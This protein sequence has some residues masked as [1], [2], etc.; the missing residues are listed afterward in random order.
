MWHYIGLIFSLLESLKHGKMCPWKA[1]KS[2][3]IFGWK[4]C[5]NPALCISQIRDSPPP[6]SGRTPDSWWE[7]SSVWCGEFVWNAARENVARGKKLKDYMEEAKGTQLR[8]RQQQNN[9]TW[10]LSTGLCCLNA[11]CIEYY[12]WLLKIGRARKYVF[13]L[14][15]Q[16]DF[17]SA[18]SSFCCRSSFTFEF[19][20]RTSCN[21]L[22]LVYL[23]CA[24]W[25]KVCI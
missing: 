19:S 9:V 12:H 2:P 1:L 11:L 25:R 15:G 21:W 24:Y 7:V 18:F 22:F 3:W 4:K 6:S 10:C 16:K 13:T 14:H 23:C 8:K 20:V 17:T 5:T